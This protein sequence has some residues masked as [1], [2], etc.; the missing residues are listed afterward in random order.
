MD[1]DER[2]HCPECD[3]YFG[4]KETFEEHIE[5]EHSGSIEPGEAFSIDTGDLK[6]RLAS[7]LNRSFA[8][9][10]VLGLVIASAGF[11]GYIY[12]NSL[13]HRTTVPVTVVT[14]D[15][16]SYDRFKTAT[17]RIFKTEYKEVDYR[18]ERGQE[19][20]QKYNIKYVPAFIF[21]SKIEEAENFYR[22]KSILV[23]FD[24]AYV[25]P[26]RSPRAA[27]RLSNGTELDR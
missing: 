15:N 4:S 12:W 9:G 25:L 27:Q 10:L 1:E 8:I 16:C 18:S 2:F 20:I 22:V 26:D 23:E 5:L 14:C 17:D 6:E 11:G 24:D 19:L 3:S 7:H 13:D 21:D